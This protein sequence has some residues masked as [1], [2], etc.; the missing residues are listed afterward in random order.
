MQLTQP[1]RD[2][3]NQHKKKILAPNEEDDHGF[4]FTRKRNVNIANK[5]SPTTV[6]KFR[7]VQHPL[8]TPKKPVLQS[9][10]KQLQE[11][12]IHIPLKETPMI[13][14]NKDIRQKR[15]R[16]S[17]EKRGKRASS[18]GNGFA[19]NPHPDVK[20]NEFFRHIQPDLP[21]PKKLRQLLT[22]CGKRAMNDPKTKDVNALKIA[23]IIEQGIL[24]D[25]MDCKINTSWYHRKDDHDSAEKAR[26]QKKAHPLNIENQRRLE[27]YEAK[28]RSLNAENEAWLNLITKYNSL[29]TSKIETSVEEKT[30]IF[31]DEVDI[32]VL[33]EEQNKFLLKYCTEN[34]NVLMEDKVLEEFMLPLEIQIDQLY[35]HLYNA[36]QFNIAT[37]IYC[38]ELLTNLLAVLRSR[39][40]G[41]NENNE[42]ETNHVLKALSRIR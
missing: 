25:L 32:S 19:A 11:S 8:E 4:I 2:K 23:K 1:R 41:K 22:W 9:S 29:C 31:P 33:P 30:C 24:N 37:H 27:E 40:S 34:N 26:Q 21:G 10:S 38:E 6:G 12:I 36:S 39:Q 17:F 3:D 16:S 13:Q 15:R 18:I 20:S 14:K 35:H 42:I 5:N 7:S 28:I